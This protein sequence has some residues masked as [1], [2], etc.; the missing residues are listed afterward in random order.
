MMIENRSFKEIIDANGELTD[1]HKIVEQLAA[2]V[3]TGS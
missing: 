1:M 3:I 2:F